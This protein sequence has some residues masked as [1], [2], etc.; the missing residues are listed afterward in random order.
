MNLLVVDSVD[1]PFGGAHSVHVDLFMKG[2]MEND[3]NAFLII[4]YGKKRE[5]L[6]ASKK[7]YGHFDGVPYYFVRESK[8]I[9]KGFRFIDNF[10]AV[11]KT[12]GLIYKRRKKKKA[13]AVII[14]GIVDILRDAPVILTCAVLRIPLYF[15]LV[16]KASLNEDHRGFT[17]FLNYKSQQLSEWLFPKFASGLI[18]ISNNLKTFYKKSF[19]ENKILINPILVSDN[20]FKTIDR[21]EYEI[22]K[23]NLEKT[24]A[25]KQILVYSGTFG[26]KDGLYYLIEAFAEVVKTYPDSIFIMTGKGFGD[27]L[28]NKIKKHIKVHGVEDK[29]KMVGFVS[30]VELLCYNTM[31]N[32]LFVCRSNSPYANHGFP[33]KLGEYCMTE[34]PIIA[35][36]VSDIADYFADNESLFIVEPNNSKAIAEKTKY[37]FEHYD[38]ALEV[39]KKSKAV[40]L[41]TFNYFEKATE[42]ADFINKTKK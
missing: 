10:I 40:A 6:A 23:Q 36:R 2:L 27:D 11:I 35:T 33:W 26:E 31:A 16:E 13:D 19:P 15:W 18:V 4:P 30:A 25:G 41:K 5:A 22:V 28:M 32:V 21:N 34:K 3:E 42:V 1:F 14:G 9:K 20:I 29:V 38:T 17:G 37:I 39:G 8:S 24:Y 7:N 12:A